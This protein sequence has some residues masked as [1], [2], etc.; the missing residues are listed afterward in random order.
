M[1]THKLNPRL[2]KS[3]GYEMLHEVFL[4][5]ATTYNVVFAADS[6]VKTAI[7]LEREHWDADDGELE[8][9]CGYDKIYGD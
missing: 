1:V 2:R 3:R 9:F 4:C 8:C 7:V 6:H 5:I